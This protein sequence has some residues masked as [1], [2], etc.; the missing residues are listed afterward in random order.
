MNDLSLITSE[1]TSLQIAQ[2]DQMGALEVDM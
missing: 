2:S 1:L